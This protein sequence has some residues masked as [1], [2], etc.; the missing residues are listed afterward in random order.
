MIPKIAK[1]QSNPTITKQI[2]VTDLTVAQKQ[3]IFI[4]QINQTGFVG[5][6]KRVIGSQT[7]YTFTYE[8]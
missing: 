5:F 7:Y 1:T 2:N 8:N 6:A 3:Q 4:N